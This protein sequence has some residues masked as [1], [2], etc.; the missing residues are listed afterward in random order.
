MK[1][2]IKFLMVYLFTVLVAT[3]IAITVENKRSSFSST[4]VVKAVE[5]KP[6]VDWTDTDNPRKKAYLEHL[7]NQSK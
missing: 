6:S 4:V 7:Y 3:I 5:D 2:E 1:K